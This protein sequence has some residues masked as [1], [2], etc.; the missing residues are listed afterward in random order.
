MN[1]TE[2]D[3]SAEKIRLIY[4]FN[5]NS[6][7]FARVADNLLKQGNILEALSILS[8]GMPDYITYPSPYFILAMANAYSGDPD[9]ART[10]VRKGAELLGSHEVMDYY[11]EKIDRIIKERNSITKSKS[12]DFDEPVKIPQEKD[13]SFDDQLEVLAQKLTGAKI[14]YK[15]EEKSADK[16]EIEEFKG[17]KIASETL[18]EIHL[19]QKNYNEALSIYKELMKKNPA[20]ADDYIL[21][22]AE[23]QNIIDEQSGIILI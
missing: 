8:S 5:N 6:P 1:S 19:S 18:A 13:E 10:A 15:P 21:K 12:V 4:E 9:A 16:V 3:F 20:K 17:E 14:N 11:F 22:I 2:K 7:L 23:I